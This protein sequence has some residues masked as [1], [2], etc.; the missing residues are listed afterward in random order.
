MVNKKI[1]NKLLQSSA[2]PDNLSLTVKG[3][4]VG[5]VPI[6][7]LIARLFEISLAEADLIGIIENVTALIAG[8]ML[9]YGL[10][11]KLYFLI[12]SFVERFRK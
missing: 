6:A 12:L 7:I 10:G 8:A 4:L 3:V 11:R 9:V 1:M 2:N 5:L